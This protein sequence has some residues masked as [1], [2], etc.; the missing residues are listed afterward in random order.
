MT[1]VYN[2]PVKGHGLGLNSFY[3]YIKAHYINITRN[4]SSIFLQSQ[5]AYQITKPIAKH[6]IRVQKASKRDG[7]WFLDLIDMNYQSKGKANKGYRYI[8]T[9]L[10]SYSR[11]VSLIALKSK[12][13]EEVFQNLTGYM[14]EINEFP[15]QLISDQGSEFKTTIMKEYAKKNNIRLT[16]QDSYTPQANIENQNKMVRTILQHTFIKN[17]NLVW[18]NQM[19]NVTDVINEHVRNTYTP[20]SEVQKNPHNTI[21]QKVGDLCRV[22]TSLFSSE[23]RK[24]NK[25]GYSKYIPV[26]WSVQVF[27]VIKVIRYRTANSL[28]RYELETQ[29]GKNVVLNANDDK[30]LRFNHTDLQFIDVTLNNELTNA[31]EAR[32]NNTEELIDELDIDDNDINNNNVPN[33]VHKDQ[34]VSDR[35]LRSTLAND[36]PEFIKKK[37]FKKSPEKKKVVEEEKYIVEKLIGKKTKKGKI[38]YKV[39]WQ[40]YSEDESTWELKKRLIIDGFKDMI[41]EY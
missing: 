17:K 9:I 29:V 14:E 10:D 41:D 16:F 21:V 5:Q 34:V 31:D 12:T 11:E 7:I 39:L 3:A 27:S 20:P 18:Y 24:L 37:L 22:K 30:P 8:M 1:E 23:I 32:L 26:K 33:V 28:P 6:N 2:D 4:Q 35:I 19:Q 25:S 13:K 40:G 36:V 15:T 38:Y